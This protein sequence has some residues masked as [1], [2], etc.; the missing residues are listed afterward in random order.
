LICHITSRAEWLAAERRGEYRAAS[1]ET[2]G[3]MH[4][5]TLEQVLAVANAFYRGRGD[6]VLLLVDET[7]LSARL[8]WEPPAGPSA[9][10]ISPA[11]RFPHLYGPLNLDAV[12]QVVALKYDSRGEF[13]LPAISTERP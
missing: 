2:E 1:L 10:G 12:L 9:S 8:E 4:A 7:R 13:V 5:S 3:F 6:L 11:G